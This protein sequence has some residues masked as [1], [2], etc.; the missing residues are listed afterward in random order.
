SSAAIYGTRAANGVILVTTKRGKLGQ[1]TQYNVNV[2]TGITGVNNKLDLLRAEDLVMLKKER[3][4]NDG[5]SENV[6]WEDPYY[7]MN[8]TD[9]QDKLFQ[10]GRLENFD[11]IGRA[12]V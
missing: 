1:P 5:I 2:Y 4:A 10:T 11:Q 9:W 6:F 7:T 8:R 12:H 3:Y